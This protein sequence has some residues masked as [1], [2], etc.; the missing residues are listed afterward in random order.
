MQLFIMA[1]VALSTY[2]ISKLFYA[3]MKSN[4]VLQASFI[5]QGISMIMMTFIGYMYFKEEMNKNK[6]FGVFLLMMAM[7]FLNK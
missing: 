3:I 1:V 7:Y 5:I 6:S 4:S 2:G